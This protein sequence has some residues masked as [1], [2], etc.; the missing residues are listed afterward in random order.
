MRFKKIFLSINTYNQASEVL[1]NYSSSK[2]IPIFYFK[3]YLVNKLSANWLLELIKI[4]ENQFG[5][6][7]FKICVNVKKNYGLFINL[8]E[9]KIDYLEVEADKEMLIKLNSIAKINKVLINPDFSVVDL[10]KSKQ[11]TKKIKIYL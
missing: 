5:Y 4:L 11:I 9:K 2:N 8:V 1:K 6:N 10:T 3:Y 7:R